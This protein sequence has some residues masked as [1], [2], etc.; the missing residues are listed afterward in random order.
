[1]DLFQDIGFP[2]DTPHGLSRL[3]AVLQSLD[4]RWYIELSFIGSGIEEAQFFQGATVPARGTFHRHNPVT[5][6]PLL[7]VSL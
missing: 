7:A 3:S 2:Q 1:M 6:F 4:N 5:N